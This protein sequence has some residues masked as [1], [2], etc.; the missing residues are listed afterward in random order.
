MASPAPHQTLK[1]GAVL[2]PCSLLPCEA[3]G[4][5]ATC[6]R[7]PPP[8]PVCPQEP[9]ADPAPG[10][11]AAVS[12]R[13]LAAVPCG[14]IEVP[15]NGTTISGQGVVLKYN[16]EL[17]VDGVFFGTLDTPDNTTD[18]RFVQRF[19]NGGDCCSQDG[20]LCPTTNYGI[21]RFGCNM[22]RT[23]DTVRR[24]GGAPGG[25]HTAS[26]CCRR[27]ARRRIA[28]R[29]TQPRRP[30]CGSGSACVEWGRHGSR[31]AASHE[32][33]KQARTRARAPPPRRS[34]SP[35]ATHTQVINTTNITIDFGF[36]ELACGRE[37]LIFTRRLW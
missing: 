17:Y 36:E 5:T 34:P 35:P 26:T 15:D 19:A 9:A 3:P 12:R 28:Q 22:S 18:D 25:R 23:A 24:A 7:S 13:R 11:A 29:R 27:A 6:P 1:N 32:R 30:C 31:L 8:R 4:P 37:V 21:V 20:S 16:Q 2:S 33:S 10:A 14:T